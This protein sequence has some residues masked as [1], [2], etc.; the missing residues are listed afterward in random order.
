MTGLGL[1]SLFRDANLTR[2]VNIIHLVLH[3]LK[4]QFVVLVVAGTRSSYAESVSFS[5]QDS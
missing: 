4:L 2:L 1:R 5:D 3:G